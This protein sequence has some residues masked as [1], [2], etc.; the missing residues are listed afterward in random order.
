MD[1]KVDIE[2]GGDYIPS[3]NHGAGCYCRD[4]GDFLCY[5]THRSRI[6]QAV[7]GLLGKTEVCGED[8]TD[9]RFVC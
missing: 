3:G 4:N 7:W 1:R 5:Y 2:I 6:S 9:S 8:L